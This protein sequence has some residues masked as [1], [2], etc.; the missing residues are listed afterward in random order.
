MGPR[1]VLSAVMA[2]TLLAVV[3]GLTFAAPPAPVRDD[4]GGMAFFE[5]KVRPMLAQRC[6]GCHSTRSGKAEGGLRLD[7]RAALRTGGQRGPTIVPGDPEKS[8]LLA[9]VSH[10]D[11]ALR[12]PPSGD[13]LPA[14]VLADLRTWIRMG[15][16]DSRTGDAAAP[17]P[18]PPV[19]LEAGRRFWAFRKPVAG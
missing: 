5:A 6:Y 19:T 10:S 14:Q 12:M 4:P 15:A 18:G 1:A 7:T 16:P 8:L 3:G 2:G 9:A 17:S 13:R 11:P